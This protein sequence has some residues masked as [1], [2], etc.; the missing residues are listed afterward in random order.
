MRDK[1]PV[2]TATSRVKAVVTKQTT[3][4]NLYGIT[5]TGCH[6]P[7][8]TSAEAGIGLPANVLW[9][10]GPLEVGPKRATDRL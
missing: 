5:C 3:M 6:S 8:Y 7:L 2:W 9:R 4:A 1:K 10:Y